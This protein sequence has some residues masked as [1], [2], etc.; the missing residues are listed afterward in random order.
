MHIHCT[1]ERFGGGILA[2]DFALHHPDRISSVVSLGIP[3]LPKGFNFE[4]LPEGFYID[5]WRV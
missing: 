4:P 1:L 2:H 3:F 5:H